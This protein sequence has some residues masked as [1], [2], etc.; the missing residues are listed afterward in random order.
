[1]PTKTSASYRRDI[2]GLRGLAIALV[3]FFHVFVGKVSSGVDIF[4][5]IGGIFFFGPQIRNA[6]RGNGLTL[7]QSILRM[8]RRLFPALLA[9]TVATL[10][11]AFFVYPPVRWPQVAKDAVASLMYWQNISLAQA[12]N[13][14]SAIGRDVSVY[15]HLWSMSAQLQ[16]YIGSLVVITLLALFIKK[17]KTLYLI[18][19][20]ATV[21]SFIYAIV[22]HV[23][24]QGWNYY[25]PFSRFWEISLGG[26]LGIWLVARALPEIWNK[27]RVPAGLVGLALVLVTGVLF[28]GA[29]QF[30][31]PL[32]LVPL[33]GAL[34][35][36]LAGN[37]NE[38]E[39]VPH[40]GGVTAFLYTAPLQFLGR[41]SYSLY[42]W[43]WP[44]LV[45]A[46]YMFS[47][48]AAGQNSG[49]MGIMSTL[50]WGKGIAVGTAV[51]VLSLLLAWMTLRW[52]ETPLR[53]A[54]KP[55]RSW[56][57]TSPSYVKKAAKSSPVK[58]GAVA[59]IAILTVATV[60]FSQMLQPQQR[61]Y[62]DA[63][64]NIFEHRDQYPGPLDLMAQQAINT[65]ETLPPA[66]AS[67]E[68]MFPE[69]SEDQCA[70]LFDETDVILTKERNASDDPCAYGDETSD[71][72]I[73]LFGNS[74]ADHF[75][76][77][78][79]I[80]AE[81][82]GIKVV[83]ILKMGCFPGGEDV[84]TDG[85]DYPECG[86]WK[87]NAEQ[88]IL[89]NPPSEGVLF[90]SSQP[91]SGTIGPETV[92]QGL[93]DIVARFSEAGIPLW[94]LRDSPWPQNEDGPINVRLCVAEGDYDP[95]EPDEDCG[96]PRELAYL[97][98]DPSIEAF[99]PF[100]V[101]HLDLSDS[102]CTDERC[103]GVV[104]N[105][106]VYRD[107]SHVTNLYS[108]LLADELERQMYGTD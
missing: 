20:V 73:Y 91:E 40:V 75:L 2:D 42:L 108:A 103:P 87:A 19:G 70:A 95:E 94:A 9:V 25:S 93:V 35:I 98:E 63:M 105:V 54:T 49:A 46:T 36:I 92:P 79:D 67:V 4:L 32:T 74:H 97:P 99:A 39:K 56:V 16:I 88:F 17:A 55:E 66:T 5:L 23:V 48:S 3:V 69:T 45:L 102:F 89:D 34:L 7:V 26:L 59:V 83:P 100:D 37:P 106:M 50:G 78:L 77:A 53:Q 68:S 101:K 60:Q 62:S 28:D 11:V 52:V 58:A 80:V 13:D 65:A 90:I 84:K 14:Y 61:T 71:R 33:L 27:W 24:D 38:Y 15:Q 41:I 43:H 31:G 29:Q 64:D 85:A 44:L 30:P 8:M 47:D 76:P 21:A 22:M 107:S 6:L 12:N 51:I 1:M 82:Q 104:G 72:T 57:I 18:V 86:V 81:R 96:T 10:L